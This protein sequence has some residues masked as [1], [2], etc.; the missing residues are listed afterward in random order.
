VTEHEVPG[1]PGEPGDPGDRRG[2]IGGVGGV[3]G[4][5]GAP[6]GTGGTGGPGGAGGR[7]GGVNG[8][9][10]SPHRER[11]AAYLLIVAIAAA[12]LWRVE[13]T[14]NRANDLALKVEE[15]AQ[16]RADTTCVNTWDARNRIREAILIPGE[17]LIEVADADPETVEL[18]RS[19]ITRRVTETI[20]DP[21]CDLEAALK[22]LDDE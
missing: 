15:E 10:F 5:G 19:A 4:P 3:G 16:T 1:E 11:L 9:R 22:R 12:G 14:A 7:G 6:S 13:T 17:A 8:G 21:D 18:F 2:G 20:L